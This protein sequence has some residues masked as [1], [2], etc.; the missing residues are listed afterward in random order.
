MDTTITFEEVISLIKAYQ[1]A[2]EREDEETMLHISN[3]LPDEIRFWGDEIHI[4]L[5]A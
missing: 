3:V 2:V 1:A 5:P 4:V